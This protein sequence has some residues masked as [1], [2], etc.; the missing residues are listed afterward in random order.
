MK[1][2]FTKLK[3]IQSGVKKPKKEEPPVKQAEE[4]RSMLQ[5]NVAAVPDKVTAPAANAPMYK[6]ATLPAKPLSAEEFTEP[7]YVRDIKKKI[8]LVF[9]TE[10]PISMAMLTRR[11]VQS[12]GI[13]RAGSRIQGH[14][15][16]ILQ[17]MN[18]KTTAQT[19]AVFCWRADQEPNAYTLFRVSGEDDHH[20][21]ARDVPMQEVANAVCVVLYEQVS[22]AQEDL[23][24]ETAK[25]L[26]YTRLGGN[27]LTALE[28]GIQYAQSQGNITTGSNGAFILSD[29]GT[30]RAEVTLGSFRK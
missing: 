10:A 3:E 22:M 5:S 11:V 20:R 4:Q 9:K 2:I 26:G 27:V 19:D 23:L 17:A 18:L 28:S 16:T 29:S 21:D 30:A 8:E 13:S 14:M 24:R 25:K 1:R 15:N 7:R 12:Y 6:A